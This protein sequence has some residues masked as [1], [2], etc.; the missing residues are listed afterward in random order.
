MGRAENSGQQSR[1][2]VGRPK[3]KHN[4]KEG[5]EIILL[6]GKGIACMTGA[7]ESLG[8]SIYAGVLL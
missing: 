3:F 7:L 8:N 6:C 5:K 2:L 4:A 1:D